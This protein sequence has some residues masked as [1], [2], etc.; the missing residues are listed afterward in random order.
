MPLKYNFINNVDPLVKKEIERRESL[1]WPAG[2]INNEAL[3]WNY[4]KTAYLIMRS[5]DLVTTYATPPPTSPQNKSKAGFATSMADYLEADRL[6]INSPLAIKKEVLTIST[7]VNPSAPILD[8][9]NDNGTIKGAIINSA[10]ITSDGT[11][12][13]ILRTTVNFTVFDRFELDRYIDN[14]LRPGRDIELEYGWTVNDNIKQN[15]GK[16]Q[17]IVYNFNFSA[18]SDGSWDCT[19]NALGPSSMTFGFGLDQQGTKKVDAD[20]LISPKGK[21]LS[22]IFKT[23]ID[24]VNVQNAGDIK[25]GKFDNCIER[26]ISTTFN[27]LNNSSGTSYQEFDSIKTYIFNECIS[28]EQ[29]FWSGGLVKEGTLINLNPNQKRTKELAD[30]V[31]ARKNAAADKVFSN[32]PYITLGNLINLINLIIKNSTQISIPLYTFNGFDENNVKIDEDSCLAKLDDV[33]KTVG[34]AHFEKFAFTTQFNGTGTTKQ[35]ALIFDIGETFNPKIDY[36]ITSTVKLADLILFNVNYLY[37]TIENILSNDTN[38][39]GKKI[40]TFLSNLF[41]ELNTNTGG[42]ISLI[43][44]DSPKDPISHKSEFIQILNEN[45]TLTKAELNLQP[46]LEFKAFTKGSVVR[47][48]SVEASVPDAIQAEVATYTR[49]NVS[50]VGSGDSAEDAKTDLIEL[51]RALKKCNDDFMLNLSIDESTTTSSLSKWQAQVQ[52]LYRKMFTITQGQTLA[53][54]KISDYN[55]GDLGTA[56]FPIKLKVTLD[57]IEGFNYGNSITSNWLPKQYMKDSIYWTV[58]KIR[59]AIQNNDW[60]TELETIY[61]INI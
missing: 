10:E 19:L 22:E 3:V 9:Y 16:I 37:S 52:G 20:L 34:P 36:S 61:R 41:R 21:S 24:T 7:M 45:Y 43:V 56:I 27:L 14:F 15:C 48:L 12:G 18:K 33:I 35:T 31:N 55:L 58:V 38:I 2:H 51:R 40:V 11:Y 53:G 5:V 4:Q 28:L 42:W 25:V 46:A 39:T 32:I 49:A 23:I 50:Y 6:A 30:A 44:T 59:H 54:K 57:G 13:S 1:Y 26:N 29:S 47:N 8:L 60:S 17:A